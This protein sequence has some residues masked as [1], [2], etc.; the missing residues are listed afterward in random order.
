MVRMLC[1]V[2]EHAPAVGTVTVGGHS[3]AV[4]STCHALAES[5]GDVTDRHYPDVTHIPLVGDEPN[6]PIP[7]GRCGRSND[8]TYHT[9]GESTLDAGPNEGQPCLV[10]VFLCD[11]CRPT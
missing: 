4:C 9:T 6:P 2:C 5:T 1:D 8:V 11:S 10:G 3:A 7:C